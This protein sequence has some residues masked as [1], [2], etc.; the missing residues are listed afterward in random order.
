[1]VELTNMNGVAFVLNS[2][3][4]ET[5]ELIPETKITTTTGKYFLVKETPDEI[6]RKVIT[7]NQKIFINVVRTSQE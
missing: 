7:F 2:N 3:L 6:V 5:I 1:M 4:I